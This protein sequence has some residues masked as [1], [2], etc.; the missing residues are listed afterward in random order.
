VVILIERN[1]VRVDGND[2][3]PWTLRT[4]QVFELRGDEWVRLHRHA[5]PLIDRRAPVETF[6]LARGDR[7]G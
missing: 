6:A 4:T 3:Q 5:D 7:P 1:T 2:E